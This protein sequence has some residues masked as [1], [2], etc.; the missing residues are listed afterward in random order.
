MKKGLYTYDYVGNN[1]V[2]IRYSNE[3]DLECDTFDSVESI[4]NQ[5]KKENTEVE[6]W[7]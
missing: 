5:M 7:T 4:I 3:T 1:K 2:K 6:L